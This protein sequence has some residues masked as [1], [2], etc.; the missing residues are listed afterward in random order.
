MP[1]DQGIHRLAHDLELRV[2]EVG[3]G[4]P[5]L[6]L[7]GGA[8]PASVTP[9]VDRLGQAYRVLAPTHPGWEG[10]PRPDRLRGV[11]ELALTY[12]DL[13][14][15]LD[16]R[17]VAVL[18]SSFG[19]WLAAEM[20]LRDTTQRI[21][22]VLLVDAIGPTPESP[23]AGPPPPGRGPSPAAMALLQSYTGPA[24]TDP[25]LR[26]RLSAVHIPVLVVW[27]E[28]DPVL[29]VAYGRADAFPDARFSVI[30]GGGHL[31]TSEAPES[32]F[33]VIGAFLE[34]TTARD[35]AA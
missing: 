7:H 1:L 12:L 22:A 24:M 10:S 5:V 17:D 29:P 31:P 6:V 16:L 34:A 26:V 9:V 21:S 20:A 18:G 27:G 32:T 11:A 4:R 13:L 19:G 14:K 28:Q 8:G 35:G 15:Q 23:P 2:R 33:A 30:P 3:T 25:G